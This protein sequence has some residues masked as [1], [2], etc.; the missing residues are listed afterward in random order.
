LRGTSGVL[1][2]SHCINTIA[3]VTSW[4]FALAPVPMLLDPMTG[5]LVHML[6]WCEWTVLAFVMTF[7]VY[8]ADKNK[9]WT[10]VALAAS[11]SASTFC[12]YLL[13]LCAGPTSW[14][15]VMAFSFAF[16]AVLAPKW[17]Q[18]RRLCHEAHAHA[19]AARDSATHADAESLAGR[20]DMSFYLLSACAP[21]HPLGFLRGGPR[22]R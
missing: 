7:I 22:P 18:R 3:A 12:G 19:A 9:A 14:I 10:A 15:V 6:R 21:L 13:P 5:C 11:Q 20:I 8:V 2:L 1:C 16:F 4:I 17:L